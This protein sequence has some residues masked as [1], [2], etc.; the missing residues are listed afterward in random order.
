MR[1][2]W[3]FEVPV[4]RQHTIEVPEGSTFIHAECL[5]RYDIV[6]VWYEVRTQNP[7]KEK[8]S[9]R[10]YGTGHNV[11]PGFKHKKTVVFR[12]FRQSSSEPVTFAWHLYEKDMRE[13]VSTTQDRAIPKERV[14][15]LLTEGQEIGEEVDADLKDMKQA[16]AEDMGF[17]VGAPTDQEKDNG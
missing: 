2:I 3:K 11:H 9:L 12:G 6:V 17:R 16:T 4:D 5:D 8:V 1:S 7:R 10:V 14:K 13:V 15:K